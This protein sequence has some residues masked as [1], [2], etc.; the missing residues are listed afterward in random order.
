MADLMNAASIE[1]VI[2]AAITTAVRTLENAGSDILTD[3]KRVART[4]LPATWRLFEYRF[5]SPNHSDTTRHWKVVK[6]KRM[7]REWCR[8]LT[9]LFPTTRT[10]RSRLWRREYR[11]SRREP[12]PL[13]YGRLRSACPSSKKTMLIRQEVL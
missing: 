6:G 9:S 5:V 3:L 8:F 4:A 7:R 11:L 2:E 12:K 13:W 1:K 10:R